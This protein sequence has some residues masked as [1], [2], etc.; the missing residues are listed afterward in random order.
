MMLYGERLM[1]P[2]LRLRRV[3][4]GDIATLVAW[5]CTPAAHGEFLTPERLDAVRLERDLDAG[6]LW[7]DRGKTF[8]VEQ[9]EGPPLGTLQYWL[10]PDRGGRAL[11]TVKIADPWQRNRG[12]G[13]EA[14]KYLIIH[15]FAKLRLEAVEM[16]TDINN[17][18]QQAC[19]RKLGF[20]LVESLQYEDH[21]V[22]RAGHL[23]R[24]TAAGFA[25]TPMY[26]F[27]YE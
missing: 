5:S 24:L 2:R 9:R 13:T 25:G 12:Y 16:Y 20:E 15:L 22:V 21:Q 23:Y 3:E 8:M 26:H 17:A 1:T 10:P 18:P 14:Q 27:C 7:T 4:R 6:I 19:L 11:M